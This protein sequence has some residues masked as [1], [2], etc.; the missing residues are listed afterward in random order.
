ML[1]KS[2]LQQLASGENGQNNGSC[3]NR[4]LL[5]LCDLLDF[6]PFFSFRSSLRAKAG[7]TM[8]GMCDGR[9]IAI[10]A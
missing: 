7:R 8:A 4:D 2:S 5:D 1:F 6:F 10:L 3:L 9:G